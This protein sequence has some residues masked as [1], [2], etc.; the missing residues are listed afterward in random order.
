MG[1][2]VALLVCVAPFLLAIFLKPII[3]CI[4]ILTGDKNTIH[5]VGNL[6][7]KNYKLPEYIP[8]YYSKHNHNNYP[9]YKK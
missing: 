9:N 2:A 8:E 4:C 7:E 3:A 6:C 1:I 5:E